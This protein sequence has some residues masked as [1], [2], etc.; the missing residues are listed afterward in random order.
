MQTVKLLLILLAISLNSIF[1]AVGT[2]AIFPEAVNTI[3]SEATN[4]GFIYLPLI[5]TNS[6]PTVF[7]IENLTYEPPEVMDLARKAGV[8]WVRVNGL[9]WSDIETSE[10]QRNWAA[11]STTERELELITNA[12]KEAI[13]VIR[14][15]P[16]WARLVATSP[17]GPVIQ[18]KYGALAN[19]MRDVV[20]RYS[21]PPYNVRYFE[22]W[23]E[24]DAPITT[25]DDVYGC[26]GY[27][28]DPYYGGRDYGKILK[29]VY[30][31]VKEANSNARLVI[32]GLLMDCD[33]DN[34]PLGKTCTMSR[35]F[36]GMLIEGA[37][38]Y[39]DVVSYHTYDYYFGKLGDF[40]NDNWHSAWNSTGPVLIAKTQ[41]LKN[42]LAKYKVTGKT[43]LCTEIAIVCDANC[44]S[45]YQQTK[46]YYLVQA[47][48]ASIAE[49]LQ[50]GIWYTLVDRWRQSGLA[51]DT[52]V[53]YPAFDAFKF[54]QTKLGSAKSGMDISQGLIRIYEIN[55]TQGKIL[56]A[57]SKDGLNQTLNLDAVPSAAFD[58]YGNS[59]PVS[60]SMQV[61][62][63]PIYIELSTPAP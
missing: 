10:G 59:L 8:H 31:K 4:S 61:A 55:A 47:Y 36:E 37:G 16:E 29:Q 19:F 62:L 20:T 32:G 17:C 33:P 49:G 52:F 2:A 25:A 46:A 30:P 22:L 41:F 27:T 51:S 24:P 34:P 53:P 48:T 38:A 28:Q 44:G 26:W 14:R 40:R 18:Q 63:A 21:A 43:L 35:Y 6:P 5:S 15:T 23:N 9:L 42:L 50:G 45:D 1:G 57:W 54:A 56:V 60:Q 7:G 11:A 39:F 13:L 3:T 12:G 58:L